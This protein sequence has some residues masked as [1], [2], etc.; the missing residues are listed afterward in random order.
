M[1]ENKNTALLLAQEIEEKH[2]LVEL[3][4]Q[5]NKDAIL[6]G[7]SFQ[8]EEQAVP[9]KLVTELR[10]NLYRMISNNFGDYLNF[11]YRVDVSENKLKSLKEIDPEKIA[12]AVTQ[13]VLE[14]EWQ[15]V[16]FKNKNR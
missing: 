12:N 4:R 15:K 1:P 10:S 11:L 16:W 2:L 13:L 8:M 6:A 7:V 14:R 9:K 3:I 5:L